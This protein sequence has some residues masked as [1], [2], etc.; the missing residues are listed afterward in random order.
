MKSHSQKSTDKGIFFEKTGHFPSREIPWG[1]EPD[2]GFTDFDEL[3][4]PDAY[5][6][7]QYAPFAG[8][9]YTP[10]PWQTIELSDE[11]R[12]EKH[13]ELED[14]AAQALEFFEKESVL[15]FAPDA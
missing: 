6:G 12:Q 4:G 15:G 3:Y 2:E 13:Q 10:N 9:L 14:M 8:S 5:M 7:D 1:E 11:I